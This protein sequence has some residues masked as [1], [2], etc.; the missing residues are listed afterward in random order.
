MSNENFETEEQSKCR[1]YAFKICYKATIIKTVWHWQKYRH[2]DQWDRIGSK[3]KPLCLWSIDF[4]QRYQGN[5][6]GERTVFL[7]NV[8][9]TI[10]Y[11]YT[12]KLI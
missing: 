6:M 1:T 11:P 2:I 9:K 10:G 5:S 3:Y 7:T 12:Q 4:G 8:A